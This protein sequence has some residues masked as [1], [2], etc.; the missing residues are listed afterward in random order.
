MP[1][2]T[3]FT[4][5][6]NRGYIIGQLYESLCRQSFR[7]FEWLVVDDGSTD[8]TGTFIAKFVAEDKIPIRFIRREN[9]GKHRAIN[10]GVREA[11]GELFFIVDSD[12]YLADNALERVAFHYGNVKDDPAFAGVSG[13][14]ARGGDGSKVGGEEAWT[15]F[16]ATFAEARFGRRRVRGDLAEVY[17][18]DVLRAFPFPEIPGEKFCPEML[19]WYQ[20]S[21]KG[22]KLRFFYEKI[23]ICEY[24]ADGLSAKIKK[25]CFANPRGT[26]RAHLEKF[27]NKLPPEHKLKAATQFWRYSFISRRPFFDAARAIGP[28]GTLCAPVGLA[29]ACV[30]RFKNMRDRVAA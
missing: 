21:R 30:S 17:R 9:G 12:D 23:Y 25:L 26:A 29:L 2:I 27:R 20:I 3:V 24:R 13:V 1:L 5:A 7:D 4:P 19:V 8:D 18:T 6:Y 10:L 11:R 16:D 28:A 14:R 22:Y 15:L